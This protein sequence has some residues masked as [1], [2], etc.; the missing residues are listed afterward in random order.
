MVLSLTTP[1]SHHDAGSAPN[2]ALGR[3]ANH[4]ADVIV[5]GRPFKRGLA[6][7]KVTLLFFDNESEAR[8]EVARSA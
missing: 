6:V 3:P 1:S 8:P 4:R 5:G 2:W 7:R